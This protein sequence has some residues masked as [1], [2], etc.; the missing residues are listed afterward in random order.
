MRIIK[1]YKNRIMYDTHS[2]KAVNLRQLGEMIRDNN[3]FMI[4]DNESGNDITRITILQ[5]LLDLERSGKGFRHLIP[6]I[7]SWLVQSSKQEFRRNLNEMLEGNIFDVDFT[8]AHAKRLVKD[9][10]K[11][12]MISSEKESFF[13]EKIVSLMDE[14]HTNMQLSI[15]RS[16]NDRL[17]AFIKLLNVYKSLPRGITSSTDNNK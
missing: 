15:D 13:V 4:F 3:E 5:L 10:I 14:L 17:E 2:S 12:D 6:A 7:I 8:Y 9:G 1:K 16:I 11:A